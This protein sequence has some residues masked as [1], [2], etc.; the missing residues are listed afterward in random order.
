MSITPAATE[1]LGEAQAQE[2][3]SEAARGSRH[4]YMRR[5]RDEYRLELTR[6]WP[7][8]EAPQYLEFGI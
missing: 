6:L 5:Q 2:E 7:L 1:N 3:Y 8:D 4:L